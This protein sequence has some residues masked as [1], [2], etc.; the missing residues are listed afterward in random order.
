MDMLLL[1]IGVVGVV[2]Y[3][4]FVQSARGLAR[5]ANRAARDLELSHGQMLQNKHSKESVT[6][7]RD[8]L[9]EFDKDW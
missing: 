2:W 6:A 4:G 7:T 5:V 3:F 8:Y 1:I 9:A